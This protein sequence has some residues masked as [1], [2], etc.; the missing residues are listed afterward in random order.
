[1]K[2]YIYKI[3]VSEGGIAM[4][5]SM[6]SKIVEVHIPE[7][8]VSINHAYGEVNCFRTYE[9]RYSKARKIMEIEVPDELAKNIDS[10]LTNKDVF[11]KSVA[12]WFTN[13]VAD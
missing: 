13:Y 3:E 7:I 8:N 10:H 12:E 4:I 11:E 2:A 6:T 9:T 1:M 5:H